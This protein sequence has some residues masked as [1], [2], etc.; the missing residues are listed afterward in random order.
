M[1]FKEWMQNGRGYPASYS[2]IAEK[3]RKKAQRLINS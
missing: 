3:D 1:E 2:K